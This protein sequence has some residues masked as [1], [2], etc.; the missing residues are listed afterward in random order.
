MPAALAVGLFVGGQGSRFGGLAKGNLRTPD[1]ARLIERLEVICRRALPGAPLVLV[2][3]RAEYA[4]L[5][6][7]TLADAPAGIGPLGGLRA[8][9]AWA[10]V[11]GHD[12]ALALA[13]DLPFV[14]TE[15]VRRLATELEEADALAPNERG[16]WHALA[17]RYSTRALPAI[18]AGIA[19]HEHS[20]QRVFDRLGPGARN[21]EVG[22][23]EL[24]AL[25][26]W[27]SPDDLAS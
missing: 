13:C 10:A 21:L 18:D 8:L 24:A 23:D 3:E 22:P 2:G 1:G 27:D 15:L 17:A 26:D 5:G 9:V 7:E 20:L 25:R 12:G 11:R 16:L 6:H 19:A 4:D 14:T